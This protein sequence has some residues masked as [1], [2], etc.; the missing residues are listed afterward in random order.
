MLIS[1]GRIVLTVSAPAVKFEFTQGRVISEEE[2][3]LT[4]EGDRSYV[5]YDVLAFCTPIRLLPILQCL[6][7]D[8][9]FCCAFSLDIP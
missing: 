8:A 1:S 2:L 6:C 9:R 5:L 7:R 3:Q 4:E